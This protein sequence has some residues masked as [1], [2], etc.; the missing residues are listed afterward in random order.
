MAQPVSVPVCYRHPSRETYVRCTRCDRPICP[1]CMRDAAV[2]HQCPECVAEGRW[3]TRTPRTA[4]GVRAARRQGSVTVALIGINVL[5]M[6]L[7]VVSAQGGGLAGGGLG[8]FV[9]T[10]TPLHEWGALV[11]RPTLF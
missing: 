3:S 6:L 8:G 9:G 2:G 5:M 7:A 11:P 10:I 4:F 1:D